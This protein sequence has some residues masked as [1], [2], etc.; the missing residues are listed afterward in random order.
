MVNRIGAAHP[1]ALRFR[2]SDDDLDVVRLMLQSMLKGIWRLTAGDETREARRFRVWPPLPTPV[3][4]TIPPATTT[5]NE[6]AMTWPTPVHS[7]ITSGSKPTSVAF[8]KRTSH[9]D[10]AQDRV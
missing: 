8:P 3:R 1:A 4:Q 10:R 2:E 5:R 9:Q 6:S 7:M